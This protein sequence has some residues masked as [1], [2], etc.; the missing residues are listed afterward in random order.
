[1]LGFTGAATLTYVVIAANVLGGA[2]AVPQA[3]KIIALGRSEGVSP[4]W[5]VASV[6]VNAGWMVYAVGVS[7]WGIFPVSVVSV[8]AYLVIVASVLRHA[9]ARRR[10][11]ATSMAAASAVITAIPL[12]AFLLGGWVAAG[13]ALGTLYGIQLS[14]AVVAVY[15]AYDVSGVSLATW[16]IAIVEA[17]LWGIYGLARLD[18]GLIALATTGTL[19]SALV[20]LRLFVRRPRH[21]RD[22]TGPAWLPA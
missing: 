12:V 7:D 16:V 1:M 15:R 17:T 9:T 19:M 6:T 4:I 20:L 5:A 10:R 22:L 14:P 8:M 18:A 11:V 21:R 13:L 2:M 3:L